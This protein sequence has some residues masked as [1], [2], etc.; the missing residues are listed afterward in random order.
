MIQETNPLNNTVCINLAVKQ[1]GGALMQKANIK[2][3]C[4]QK[5]LEQG[6]QSERS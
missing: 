3:I 1:L 5:H 2:K 4:T 6:E